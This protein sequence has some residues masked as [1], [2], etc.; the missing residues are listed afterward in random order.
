MATPRQPLNQVTCFRRDTT[1][2]WDCHAGD[3]IFW[4]RW[5]GGLVLNFEKIDILDLWKMKDGDTVTITNQLADLP[6]WFELHPTEV[7]GTLHSWMGAKL[8]AGDIPDH[9]M[10]A[11]NL[12]KILAGDRVVWVR[13]SRAS[14]PSSESLLALLDF[15]ECALAIGES[16]P[17]HLKQSSIPGHL[18]HDFITFGAITDP[19]ER[20]GDAAFEGLEAVKRL[21]I[22]RVVSTAWMLG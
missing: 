20:P 1:V 3:F 7:C 11:A 4:L 13:H 9:P 16:D 12:W 15:Y 18:D 21:G 19:E 2:R 14:A 10:D 6:T 5:E 22:P 17:G 8:K